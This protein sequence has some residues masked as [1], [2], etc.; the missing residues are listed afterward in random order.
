[1]HNP[2]LFTHF[3]GWKGCFNI[4]KGLLWMTIMSLDMAMK[5]KLRGGGYIDLPIMFLSLGE[6]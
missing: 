6:F 2:Q 5:F 4:W 1:M 3:I